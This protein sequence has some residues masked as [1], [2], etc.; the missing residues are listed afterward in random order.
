[1][2][3]LVLGLSLGLALGLALCLA[4]G[5]LLGLVLGLALGL[6]LLTLDDVVFKPF[7]KD[8]IFWSIYSFGRRYLHDD[9]IFSIPELL[10]KSFLTSFTIFHAMFSSKFSTILINLMLIQKLG[11]TIILS[12]L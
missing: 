8:K 12:F 3:G 4:L 9:L 7:I 10:K 11:C 2:L 1:M 5:L 6:S